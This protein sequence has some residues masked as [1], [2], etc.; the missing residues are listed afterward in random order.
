MQDER[1]GPSRNGADIEERL[2]EFAVRVGKAIDAL[3]DTRLGRHIAGQL[4]RSGTSPAPNY[5]EACAAESKKDFIHKLAIVLK[6]LR[7]SSVWIRLIVKSELIPEQR[8]ELLRDECDQLC[9]IIAKSLVT[10]KSNQ[11][12]N[13]KTTETMI[14]E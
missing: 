4:V 2:L 13:S 7:E 8:L 12:R 6:E 14:N 11:S 3:P 10:A 5:A 1:Q 9:K